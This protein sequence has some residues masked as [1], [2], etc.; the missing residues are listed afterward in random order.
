MLVFPYHLS[1]SLDDYSSAF[2]WANKLEVGLPGW[3]SNDPLESFNKLF[4][5]ARTV[6]HPLLNLLD[7]VGRFYEKKNIESQQLLEKLSPLDYKLSKVIHSYPGTDKSFEHWNEKIKN[8][9]FFNLIKRAFHD[10]NIVFSAC[11]EF[12]WRLHEAYLEKNENEKEALDYFLIRLPEKE[13][14][15]YLLVESFIN[16][17]SIFQEAGGNKEQN[18]AISN[19]DIFNL[20]SAFGEESSIQI[21]NEKYVDPLAFNFFDMILSSYLPT[22]IGDDNYILTEIERNEKEA[23]L[24]LKN[25]CITKAKSVIFETPRQEQINHFIEKSISEMKNE[26]STLLKIDRKSWTTIYQKLTEDASMWAITAGAVAAAIAIDSTL[27]TA[28]AGVTALSKFT[29]ATLKE[30]R[31]RKKELKASDYRVVYHIA[32]SYHKK[33]SV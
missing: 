10:E 2:L 13:P 25:K 8:V 30:S 31:H 19:A 22:L 33:L 12:I 11:V 29:A 9:K 21:V 32:K 3:V 23:L 6:D 26:I 4:A 15:D 27:L 28:T 5:F 16:R 14:D 17:F 20:C 24:A 7:I 1:T 18:P